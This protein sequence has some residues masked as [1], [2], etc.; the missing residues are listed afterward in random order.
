MADPTISEIL[1]WAFADTRKRSEKPW[2]NLTWPDDV[3]GQASC[4]LILADMVKTE[5]W[6][7]EVRAWAYDELKEVAREYQEKSVA[8]SVPLEMFKFAFADFSGAIERP[9]RPKGRPG[10]SEKLGEGLRNRLVVAAVAWLV[11]RGETKDKAIDMV[12]DASPLSAKRI[13]SILAESN[14]SFEKAKA[15]YH[16]HKIKELLRVTDGA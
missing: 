13:E 14:L 8:G 15:R 10:Q 3:A 4:I 16:P 11:G 2:G 1:R 6:P 5:A 7:Y 9:R 12:D